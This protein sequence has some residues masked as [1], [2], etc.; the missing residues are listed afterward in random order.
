M[1][2]RM[3]VASFALAVLLVAGIAGPLAAEEQVP[4]KGSLA[5][6]VTHAPDPPFDFVLVEGEGKGT[7]LGNFTFAAPHLVN[8]LTRTAVGSYEFT[9]ANGD[10]L[11]A[12]FTGQATPTSTSGVIS[13]VESATIT[14]GTGRFAGATGSFTVERLFDRIAD[15]TSGSFEG[16]LCLPDDE[17][18]GDED[19]D[20][21][22]DEEHD[23]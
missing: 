13:I 16:T 6:L 22:D 12:E 10:T 9:A 20:N 21:E 11:S 19:E 5:G 3:S 1:K 14:S 23:D 8:T 2:R 4:F 15:T 18:D 7:H 17:D